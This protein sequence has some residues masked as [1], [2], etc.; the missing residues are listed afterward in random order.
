M[1][2]CNKNFVALYISRSYWIVAKGYRLY[3][4]DVNTDKLT[5]FSRLV[6]SKNALL[7]W[8]RLSRRLFRAEVTNLQ[9]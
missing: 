8:F 9:G 7:S 2:Y 1:K 4:Y 6:D 3:K 5:Y